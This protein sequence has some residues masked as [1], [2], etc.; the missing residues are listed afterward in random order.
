MKKKG[1]NQDYSSSSDDELFDESSSESD[2]SDDSEE[3][4]LT[5]KRKRPRFTM[6]TP[7]KKKYKALKKQVKQP[8][9]PFKF[10]TQNQDHPPPQNQNHPFQTYETFS[11]Q[12]QSQG[13]YG[14]PQTSYS[15]APVL[16]GLRPLKR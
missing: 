13:A 12:G 6:K 5:Y 10:V 2:D 4:K 16:A 15:Q 7:Y 9:M 11:A 14:I 3:E 1:K 8:G